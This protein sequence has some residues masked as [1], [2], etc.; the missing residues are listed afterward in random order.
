MRIG[1]N[2]EDVPYIVPVNFGY[3]FDDKLILYFHSAKEGKK[4]ELIKK[5]PHVFIEIDVDGGI[6]D[7]DDGMACSVTAH[8]KSV[9]A[10]GIIM[11]VNDEVKIQAFD[12]IMHH[13]GLYDKSYDTRVLDKT[14][15]YKIEV[16]VL[17]AKAHL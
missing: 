11:K 2:D 4:I 9:M 10:K 15:I 5:D 16:S 6:K 13:Y 3:T 17:S 14:D 7:S 12:I 8:Y 1:F